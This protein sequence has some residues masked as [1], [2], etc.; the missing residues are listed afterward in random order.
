VIRLSEPR[1]RQPQDRQRTLGY[2][3]LIEGVKKREREMA[4]MVEGGVVMRT[5]VT[6]TVEGRSA[7]SGAV[8]RVCDGGDGAIVVI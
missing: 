6:R 1:I 4:V 7:Y 8:C 2:H 5:V 3:A